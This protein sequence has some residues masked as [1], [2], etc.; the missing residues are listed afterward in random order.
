MDTAPLIYLIEGNSQYQETLNVFFKANEDGGILMASSVLTI[1]EILIQPFKL[2][3]YELALKYRQILSGSDNF[4]IFDINQETAFQAAELRAKYGIKTPDA[5]QIASGIQSKSDY[6]L[7]NDFQ[8]KKVKEIEVIL[9][10]ELSEII[11]K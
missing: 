3:K 10:N 2:G 6:F 9:I 5:I 4:N 1:T 11:L 8:L 7:T